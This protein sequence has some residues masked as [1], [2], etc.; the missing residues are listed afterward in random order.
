MSDKISVLVP[1][2][3][4]RETELKRLFESLINQ[5]Y[6]KLE[7][8]I[9]VQDNFDLTRRIC[10]LYSRQLDI[11]Y[12]ETSQMGLSK[13]R[14]IGIEKATGDI[15]LL[16]DDDC[17][18]EKNSLKFISE[19]FASNAEMDILISK[20]YDP[21]GNVDYKDYPKEATSLKKKVE[22]L[23][24]SS[25]E[26]AF[27]RDKI[28]I[29]FDELFGLGARYVAGEE[30]DFLI[31]A[32]KKGNKIQYEPVVTVYHEKK[33][34]R[35]SNSQL[36]A[37]GAFYAKHFGFF[38]SNLVLLRDLIIKHQNN[39]RWFWNGYIGYKRNN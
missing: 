29:K 24:K 16:S 25:I 36:V 5:K 30:N 9:V 26:I 20:I 28:D 7:I 8:V 17:W 27:K 14:N 3:G 15:I 38:V 1:T 11:V 4:S 23:S 35:E 10:N 22:L 13:A 32:L 6:D 31:R 39:Y 34:T 12:I 18:Y 21:I 2:L 37:K 33:H 19:F